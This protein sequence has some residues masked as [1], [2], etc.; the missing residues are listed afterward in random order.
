MYFRNTRRRSWYLAVLLVV[1][2][3]LFAIAS[4]F[5]FGLGLVGINLQPNSVQAFNFSQS[6]ANTAYNSGLGLSTE[7]GGLPEIVGKIIY[8]ALGLVGV[9]FLILV[10][11]AG[12]RWMTAG[13][14]EE[15]VAEAKA[16]LRRAGV[17]VL[18]VLGAYA[19]TFFVIS[20][21]L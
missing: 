19:I 4:P 14:N 1:T 5:V 21:L 3:I 10:I 6:L 12:V 18:I 13:G 2:L 7:G 11:I 20:A 17:G 8:S 16:S 9:V 15:R